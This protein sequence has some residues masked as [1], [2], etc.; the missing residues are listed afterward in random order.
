MI[1][2]YDILLT[3]FGGYLDDYTMNIY[4]DFKALVDLIFILNR[5]KF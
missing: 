3:N 2:F 1:V 5:E 4:N